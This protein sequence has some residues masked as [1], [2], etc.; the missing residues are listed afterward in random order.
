MRDFYASEESRY[1][2]WFSTSKEKGVKGLNKKNSDLILDFCNDMSLGLNISKMSKRG[3]RSKKRINALRQKVIFLLNKLE[4]RNIKDIDNLKKEELHKLFD[5]MRTGVILN[6]FGKPYLST[7]D[8]VKDFKVFWHWYMKRFN[9]TEDICEELDRR[10]EKPKFVYF[11]QEEFEKMI[12]VASR[13]L[14]IVMILLWDV[15]CRVKELMNIKVKD[16]YNDFKE[17]QIQNE[18][19]K[20]FGRKV[21]VMFSKDKVKDYIKELDLKNEDYLVQKSPEMCNNELNKIGKEILG[22]DRTKEKN[23][24]MYDFRHSSACYWVVRYKSESALKYRFGWKKSEMIHYY[25]EFLGMKDTIQEDDLYVDVTKTELEKKIQEQDKKMKEMEDSFNHF[26]KYVDIIIEG[27]YSNKMT[28]SKDS[29]KASI[30]RRTDDEME[31]IKK[32]PPLPFTDEETGEI[33]Y[34][35]I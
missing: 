18:T 16:F 26:K 2:N 11:N 22:E 31:T 13:D 6:R 5:D 34:P 35:E 25:T 12:K 29:K 8:Y 7:G 4:E 9:K 17:L 23:L 27:E 3:G 24:T 10:G 19:A 21:K 28:F 1:D 30:K 14:Q 32:N 20:T 33:L 15:G